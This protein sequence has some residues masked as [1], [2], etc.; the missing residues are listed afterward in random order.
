MIQ[1][2]LQQS[3]IIQNDTNF[4]DTNI[5]HNY[6]VTEKADGQRVLL[7]INYDGKIYFVNQTMNII[8]SGAILHQRE[9]T[10]TLL[11]GELIKYNKKNDFINLFMAFDIYYENGQDVRAKK[12]MNVENNHHNSDYRY[13][14][15]YQVIECLKINMTS[16]IKNEIQSPIMIG[17]K[18][19]YGHSNNILTNGCRLIL[20]QEKNNLFSYHID[21]LIFTHCEYGVGSNKIG[22]AGEKKNVTWQHS[23]KWKPE[24]F[25]T[26]DF[27]VTDFPDTM[28]YDEI[29]DGIDFVSSE[30]KKYKWIELR[31]GFSEKDHGF[32]NPFYDVIHDNSS[33]SSS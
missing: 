16:V 15:L 9:Y 13:D 10:N 28:I 33:S 2:T 11:D 5:L 26:I 24:K 21:G 20:Q 32:M 12:F 30:N 8:F 1:I 22:E 6:V 17:I 18:Q 31:C 27:L 25:N 19:F 23:M 14:K 4:N 3:H 29:V 7:Y